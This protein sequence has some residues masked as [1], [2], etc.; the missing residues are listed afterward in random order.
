MKREL[1]MLR[2]T[3]DSDASYWLDSRDKPSR[4]LFTGPNEAI[5]TTGDGSLFLLD[6]HDDPSDMPTL[7]GSRIPEGHSGGISSMLVH[8]HLKLLVTSAYDGSVKLWNLRKRCCIDVLNDRPGTVQQLSASAEH[9]LLNTQDG[10]V[11]IVR[12]RDGSLV[13]AFQGDKQIVSS[14][15][16]PEFRY[17][18][19]L[20]Q[21]GQMHF[22]HLEPD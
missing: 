1:G 20:D 9:I 17:I 16:D 6:I 14:D 11:N 3:L 4:M 2:S 8:R 18:V 5:A 21:S 12:V 22:L 19:A 10:L 15:S 7:E 13:A